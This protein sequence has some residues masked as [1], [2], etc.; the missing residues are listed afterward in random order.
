MQQCLIPDITSAD[1]IS[2]DLSLFLG[3]TFIS[4]FYSQ[5]TSAAICKSEQIIST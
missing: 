3:Q 1:E 5:G 2:C 4:S